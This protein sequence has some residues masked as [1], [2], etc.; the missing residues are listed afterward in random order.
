MDNNVLATK[1]KER[2]D[3]TTRELAKELNISK[4]TVHKYLVSLGYT[5]HYKV[6]VPDK[7]SEK[8]C[9]DRYSICNILLK[10]NKSMP[11]LKTL[12]TRDKKWIVY[13]NV[14]QKRSW[15]LRDESPE[16]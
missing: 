16:Q 9:L 13:D 6:W 14:V 5:S 4:S 1:I 12:V 8:N 15:C 2:P 10:W 7:L 3:I 11:F